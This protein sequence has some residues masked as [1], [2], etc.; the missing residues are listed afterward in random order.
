MKLELNNVLRCG[1]KIRFLLGGTAMLN[2]MLYGVYVKSGD[3]NNKPK[4]RLRSSSDANFLFRKGCEAVFLC[5]SDAFRY[6]FE[7]SE[8]RS[9]EFD[10]NIIN[11][12]ED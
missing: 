9:V 2:N 10:T 4:M 11:I 1:K 3:K 5:E 8:M 7:Q 6:G 12:G